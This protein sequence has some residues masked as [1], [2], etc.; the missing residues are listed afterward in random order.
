MSFWHVPGMP[1]DSGTR[2][3]WLAELAGGVVEV[4]CSC[5]SEIAARRFLGRQRHPG[6]LDGAAS[7]DRVLKRLR[8]IPQSGMLEIGQ[9]VTV[10]TSQTPD[11]RSLIDQLQFL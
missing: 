6:H 4:H 1:P 11:L 10:D 2:T 9:R 3:E 7:F 5:P 8:A